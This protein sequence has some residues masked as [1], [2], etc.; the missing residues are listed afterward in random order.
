MTPLMEGRL[1]LSVAQGHEEFQIK[2]FF[3][4]MPILY[5]VNGTTLTGKP[6]VR[7]WTKCYPVYFNL[8]F[9]RA[10]YCTGTNNNRKD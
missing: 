8:V 6:I 4:V 9:D 5:S 2:Y 3:R 7:L 1:S 10:Y